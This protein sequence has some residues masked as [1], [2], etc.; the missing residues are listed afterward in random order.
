MASIPGPVRE[1][2]RAEFTGLRDRI[3]TCKKTN[4]P[5]AGS[6]ADLR[7]ADWVTGGR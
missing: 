2:H 6:L 1:R 4:D 7:K 5:A 3:E